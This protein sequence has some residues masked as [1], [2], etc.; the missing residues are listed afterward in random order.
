[1]LALFSGAA[2]GIALLYALLPDASEAKRFEELA[3]GD[4]NTVSL[5]KVAGIPVHCHD[6]DDAHRC[7]GG[8]R[9]S[10]PGQDVVLWLGNSQVHAINQMQPGD[11]TAA[12]VLHRRV[13]RHGRY[14]L[15][16]SQPNASLQEHYVLFQY[17][18]DQ[19]P[20]KTLVLPVVFDDMRETG[21]RSSLRGALETPSVAARLGETGVGK[22]LLTDNVARDAAGNDMAA[23]QD[24][25]QEK[26]EALLNAGLESIWPI[27]AQRP[28][29]RGELFLFLY[30]LRNWALGIS[31][32]TIRK[33]IPGRYALNRQALEATLDAARAR[34]IDV[35]LYIV[36]LRSDGKVPYD[37]A[38]YQSFKQ[39]MGTLALAHGVRFVN[40]EDLVPAELWGA[41]AATAVGGGEEM[42]FMHFQAG[43]HALLADALYAELTA[44]WAGEG[45]P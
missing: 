20:V 32:S 14:F 15:T 19:V 37:L 27:W 28:V 39:Q 36:P 17:L 9:E 16:F 34:G 5:A 43:G 42:D 21:I 4:E 40:L 35:L 12:L 31:P 30:K 26:S 41:K 7:L 22:R 1:M 33:M 3:L 10:E 8:Y 25:V 23:L 45:R 13:A 6:L 38:E 2:L 24:T 11:E 44:L 29:L 18:L